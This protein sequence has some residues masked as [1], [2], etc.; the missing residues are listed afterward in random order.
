M[1]TNFFLIGVFLFSFFSNLSYAQYTLTDDDVVVDANGIIQSCTYTGGGYII[2]PNV[3]DGVT[4]VGIA[5]TDPYNPMFTGL[6]SVVLPEGLTSIGNYAFAENSLSGELVLPEGVSRIGSGAFRENS[7]SGELVLPEGLIFIGS[8]AFDDNSLSGDLVLPEG[9]TTINDASFRNNSFNGELVLPEGLT[10]IGTNA[11]QGN[12]F[13]GVLVLPEGLLSIEN[14]VFENNSFSGE[15]VLPEGITSIGS[16]AF[17]GSSFSGELV[18][19][20][21][22]T[23]IGSKAFNGSSFSGVLVLPNSL[24]YIGP[25]AFYNN[26][27][28]GELVLP[29]GLTGIDYRAFHNNSFSGKL[30]YPSSVTFIYSSAF[31]RNELTEIDFT[32]AALTGYYTESEVHFSAQKGKEG[33]EGGGWFYDQEYT[34]AIP[35]KFELTVD[36]LNGKKIYYQYSPLNYTIN[37]VGAGAHNN[38]TG[39]T[40]ES[41]T[42]TLSA[43]RKEGY[44][45]EGWYTDAEYTNPITEITTG[46]TGD[47]TLYAKFTEQV[48]SSINDLPKAEITTYPNPADHIVSFSQKVKQVQLYTL[49][50]V[51]LK[52]YQDTDAIDVS[53][54]SNGVYILRGNVNG[55]SFV[56]KIVIKR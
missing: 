8:Y 24:E 32:N 33:Y 31:Y 38:P 53:V 36:D 19:P 44:D 9:L 23:V 47:L 5:N 21:G 34:D 20:E 10:F 26:S 48:L 52:N 16:G 45:F 41:Q 11:F 49:D 46:S 17:N 12:S 39:Y 4:V 37:Y 40:I 55:N 22:L 29:E 1:H 35:S 25:E 3:L 6:T 18:L 7:L 27:F 54:H 42:I 28:S 50:G 14:G 2:I 56:K 13:T 43:G 30:V 15:L 51:L